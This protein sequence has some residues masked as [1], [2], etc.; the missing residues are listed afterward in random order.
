[1]E[2]LFCFA[3]LLNY[4]ISLV[5]WTP[6]SLK[7]LLKESSC[8]RARQVQIV[9]FAG[10]LLHIRRSQEQ[11]DRYWPLNGDKKEFS[12]VQS[13]TNIWLSSFLKTF[14]TVIPALI[15]CPWVSMDATNKETKQRQRTGSMLLFLLKVIIIITF[16]LCTW[17]PCMS[18]TNPINKTMITTLHIKLKMES[19]RK[20]SNFNFQRIKTL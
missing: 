17:G 10:K 4:G 19:I 18:F 20:L 9:K 5:L 1:M 16:F 2:F 6:L 14:A 12:C 15:D 11:H 13:E 3:C 8:T 7:T